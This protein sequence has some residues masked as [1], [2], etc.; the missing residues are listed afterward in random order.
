MSRIIE[1]LPHNPQWI[2]LFGSE[3]AVLSHVFG[4]QIMAVH[5]IGSTAVPGLLAKPVIDILVEVQDINQVDEYNERMINLGYEPRGE[6]GL[7]G[8]RYFPKPVD[9]R[10]M[11]HVHIW[12]SGHPEIARHLAFRDYLLSFPQQAEAYGRLKEELVATHAGDRE[13]YIT[14]KEAFC[15]ELETAALAWQHELDDLILETDRLHLIPLSPAQLYFALYRPD[16]L[17]A[18]FGFNISQAMYEPP[19][20]GVIQI[21]HKRTTGK[22]IARAIWDTYWLLV[23]DAEEFGAGLLGFKGE[24]DMGSV[25]IGYGIDPAF[26]RRGYATEAVGRLVDW[27]LQQPGCRM[28]TAWTDKN[29]AASARVVQKV[30]MLMARETADQFYWVRDR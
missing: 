12:Q 27:A 30:G 25:E 23:I 10:R 8:R 29:N 5:H 2:T 18:G 28:V 9:G 4:K 14:G 19:V 3:A 15:Q 21:K 7:P 26:R 6:Y 20:P 17:E 24:P 1:V 22:P 13:K 11:Y 16:Q